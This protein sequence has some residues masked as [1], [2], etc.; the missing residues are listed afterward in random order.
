MDKFQIRIIVNNVLITEE[1]DVATHFNEFFNKVAD[2]LDINRPTDFNSDPLS[3]IPRLQASMQLFPVS[4]EEW[5]THIQSLKKTKNY[6]K[7]SISVELFKF[8]APQLLDSVIVFP[9]RLVADLI[10]LSMKLKYKPLVYIKNN[11]QLNSYIV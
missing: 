10:F 8:A 3:N 5:F 11:E 7:K 4:R 9:T 1:S 2:N 6:C